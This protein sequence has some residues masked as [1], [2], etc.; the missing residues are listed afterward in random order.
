MAEAVEKLAAGDLALLG[1]PVAQE[2][3]ASTRMARVAYNGLDGTPRV[4]PVWFHWDGTVLVVGTPAGSPKL[5]AISARPQVAVTIDRETWPYHVLSVRGTASVEHLDDVAPEYVAAARRY[6]GPEQ[7]EA[8]AKPLHGRPM[9]RIRITPE[10]V[11]VL[12]FE[13]RLPRAL[14]G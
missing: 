4:V 12:D 14:S 2:L 8:W 13:R 6:F 1:D 9:G 3:L 10:W 11:N 5:T 7:G